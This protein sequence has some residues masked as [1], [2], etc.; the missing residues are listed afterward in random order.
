MEDAKPTGT[1]P[2]NPERSTAATAGRF[3]RTIKRRAASLGTQ[4]ARTDGFCVRLCTGGAG[5][6]CRSG[7]M[8][9]ARRQS[10]ART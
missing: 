5:S 2:A 6:C 7:N 9:V 4:A 3:K 10:I 8:D 1:R